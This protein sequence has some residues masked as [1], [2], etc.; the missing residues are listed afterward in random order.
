MRPLKLTMTGF[1]PYK[2]EAV[3]DMESL[4]SGGL[5]LV[6]GDTGAGKTYIFDAITYA[7]YGETS[8]GARDSRSLRSQ[9]ADD[10]DDTYVELVFE[11]SGKEYTVKRIPEYNRLKKRGEGY[12]R[13]SASA[14]L[15]L[16]DGSVVD[17]PARVTDAVR[18]ILGIDRGQFCNIVMIAQGEFRKVLNA[19]TEERQ[20]LFRKLFDTRP[21]N[22]LADELKTAGKAADDEYELKRRDIDM[23]LANVNC[24]FDDEI[25]SDLDELKNSDNKSVQ[26]I[27]DMLDALITKG[28]SKLNDTAEALRKAEA[29]L[30]EATSSL[31]II[32]SYKKNAADL[33]SAKAGAAGFEDDIRTAEFELELALQEKPA[34]E[35]LKNEA[36]VMESNLD[37]YDAL[38][39]INREIEAATKSSAD[40]LADVKRLKDERK[41]SKTMAERMRSE[42]DDLKFSDEKMTRIRNDIEKTGN[43]ISILESLIEE[44]GK[45]RDLEAKLE[46]QQDELE[47]LLAEAERMDNEYSKAYSAFLRGQAGLLAAKLVEGR[48]CP[49]CGSYKHPD[50]AKI[51]TEIVS[52]DEIEIKQKAAR[53]AREIAAEKAGEAQKTK[54][55]LNALE[56][57]AK[58]LA[59][60]ETGNDDLEAAL[61]GAE[62]EIKGLREQIA[63]LKEMEED[64]NNKLGQKSELEDALADAVKVSEELDDKVIEADKELVRINSSVNSLKERRD[65]KARGLQFDSRKAAEEHVESIK[66]KASGIE[67]TIEEAASNVSKAKEARTQNAVRIEELEK[68]IAGSA[69]MDEDAVN[70]SKEEAEEKKESL[71]GLSTTINAELLNARNALEII[72][73]N[74]EVLEK[75]RKQH[76]IIDPLVRTATGSVQG[77]D[78][79]SLETYVQTF[80]FE[81]IIRRANLRLV[82]MSGGQY[83]FVR[84]GESGDRRSHFGLD[85][86]VIDHY[87]GTERPVNT[88]SGG[89]SFM[90]SLSLALG[91]SDEVQASAGGIKLDT[92]FVD[93]GFGSLDSE[94]LESAIRTLTELSDEDRLVGIISHVEALKSRI[95]KQ[96]IVTKDKNS[97]SHAKVVS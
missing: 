54:G 39:D 86:S 68:V 73:S 59:R 7:L 38:D 95:D 28:G 8:G 92:M 24:S 80:Y 44:I 78:R 21:Y 13:E 66:K 22:D 72:K 77:K 45:V 53:E 4:G 29:E 94:T 23:A 81:R 90:A 75:V 50:P 17:G 71:T 57:G 61:K 84:S 37:S 42:L 25:A 83:E 65:E 91:L 46:K 5:Y 30:T 51:S 48:P 18:E 47:P 76:E 56:F 41:A 40:K 69:P 6:T 82:R 10:G 35:S 19:T 32:N 3:I 70:H 27:F 64:I 34:I 96:I 67:L 11:Y 16:P 52:A 85:L 26:Q 33:E 9:Y 74:A 31:A 15:Y 93:E 49:V 20:K 60:K 43:K 87:S 63:S 62:D 36:A 58:A 2:E 55:S 97:G 14:E 88:L 1:G 79:I 89:E 12:T